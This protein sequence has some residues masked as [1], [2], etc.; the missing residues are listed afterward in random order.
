MRDIN[1]EAKKL[2]DAAGDEFKDIYR[3]I[4]R[5]NKEERIAMTGYMNAQQWRKEHGN[6]PHP[7]STRRGNVSRRQRNNNSTRLDHAAETP[8]AAE[9]PS[10]FP[11][12]LPSPTD[13]LYA[14]VYPPW[15]APPAYSLPSTSPHPSPDSYFIPSPGASPEVSSAK[16][17]PES[18]HHSSMMTGFATTLETS[19]SEDSP[20]GYTVGWGINNRDG[21]SQAPAL[22]QDSNAYFSSN[23][24]CFP[25]NQFLEPLDVDMRY[26]FQSDLSSTLS[27]S[28]ETGAI[29][30]CQNEAV[31]SLDLVTTQRSNSPPP[32]L[33]ERRWIDTSNPDLSSA[34]QEYEET[35]DMLSSMY[36][37]Y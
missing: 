12:P 14:S 37:S 31:N 13:P 28:H 23:E 36:L 16:T 15:I 27:Y 21:Y 33:V 35:K 17:S 32:W 3:Q 22:E 34:L 30:A 4:W 24:S 6:T 5:K 19:F 2:W 18:L 11:P 26:P 9:S 10:S 8:F 20:P 29:T 1:L 7:S 25:P